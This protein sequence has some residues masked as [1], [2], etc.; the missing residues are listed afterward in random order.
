MLHFIA[1]LIGRIQETL[2][3]S[4]VGPF[5]GKLKS[6]KTEKIFQVEKLENFL[7]QIEET[8]RKWAEQPSS[9]KRMSEKWHI[10]IKG[11]E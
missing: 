10:F 4:V 3:F 6:L 5:P 2:R 11:G 7:R 8:E 9:K 1:S